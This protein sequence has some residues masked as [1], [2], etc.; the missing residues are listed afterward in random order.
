MS[1]E[2]NKARPRRRRWWVWPAFAAAVVCLAAAVVVHV[3][4]RDTPLNRLKQQIRSEVPVGSTRAQVEAWSQTHLNGQIPALTADPLPVDVHGPTMLER[5]GIPPGEREAVLEVVVPCGWY[6][7]RGE[8]AQNHM[9][10]FFPLNARGE[11]TG[12]YFLTLE[13]LAEIEGH[14]TALAPQ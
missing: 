6:T 10:T 12:Q 14:R 1:A 7:I 8:V 2:A 13:E 11:V 4:T 9:F 3:F 5:A